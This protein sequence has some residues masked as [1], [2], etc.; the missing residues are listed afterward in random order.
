VTVRPHGLERVLR[1]LLARMLERGLAADL[2][3]LTALVTR[4]SVPSPA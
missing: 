2:G 3:R 1:P 4:P